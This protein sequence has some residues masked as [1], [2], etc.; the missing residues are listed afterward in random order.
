MNLVL[1]LLANAVVNGALFAVMAVGFGLIYR[2]THVFHLAYGALLVLSGH[3]FYSFVKLGLSWW[4]AGAV[5]VA[6]SAMAGAATEIWFHRPLDKRG[7]SHTGMMVASLGIGIALENGLALF[8]GNEIQTVSRGLA[9]VIFLGPVSLTILQLG[10][11][12][13]CIA[14]LVGLAVT[15]KLPFFKVL[16]VMG[17]NPELLLVH[18]W[19]LPR[20]RAVAC[21]LGTALAAVP[22]CLTMLDIGM[23]VHAGM[24]Y[25]LIAAVAVLVGG[26]SRVAGWVLG[27]FALALLQNLLA[28]RFSTK[29]TELVA[30]LVL[31]AVL[32]FRREGL[33]GVDKRAEES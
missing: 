27:G 18:G 14:L 10:E 19:K 24:G 13:L 9:P 12:T 11:L 6:M 1:Q 4:T 23:D 8:Y 31:L 28:W 21:A 17:E 16:Q 29:W 30:F 26:A 15:R 33:L 3:L 20:Y 7:V 5:V 32:L 2:S 25:V 22:A